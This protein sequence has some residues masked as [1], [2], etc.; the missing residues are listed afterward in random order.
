MYSETCR[1]IVGH[2]AFYVK[3]RPTGSR[4][5]ISVMPFTSIHGS[6]AAAVLFRSR[7]LLLI[8][9]NHSEAAEQ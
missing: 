8:S 3:V 4:A 2:R 9:D 7:S 1:C 6:R 5:H